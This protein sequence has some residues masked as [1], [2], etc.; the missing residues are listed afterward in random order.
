MLIIFP[1]E[2]DRGKVFK[3]ATV[4]MASLCALQ[5]TQECGQYDR[6]EGVNRVCLSLHCAVG[7]G[8]VNC[9]VLGEGQVWEYL[10]AGEPLHQ[11]GQGISNAEKG[12]VCLSSEAYEYVQEKLEAKRSFPTSSSY[13]LT[14]RRAHTVPKSMSISIRN[15]FSGFVA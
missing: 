11:I 13:I 10:V 15:S 8:I 4:L 12:E 14:G 6:G 3:E 7:C 9:M 2:K 5:L 1:I